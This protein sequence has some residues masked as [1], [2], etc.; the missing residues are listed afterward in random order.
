MPQ[1]CRASDPGSSQGA[2]DPNTPDADGHL[3]PCVSAGSCLFTGSHRYMLRALWSQTAIPGLPAGNWS[4]SQA[5]GTYGSRSIR[6]GAGEGF[7]AGYFAGRASTPGRNQNPTQPP[8]IP[9]LPQRPVQE[10]SASPLHPAPARPSAAPHPSLCFDLSAPAARR[11]PGPP[12]SHS[13]RGA[14]LLCWSRL[15][16]PPS[17]SRRSGQAEAPGWFNNSLP[18]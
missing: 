5:R 4:S 10:A 7:L 18:L 15:S 11:V 1:K 3:L 2:P 14:W 12:S 13:W 17:P 6:Q 16:K 9:G 8:L